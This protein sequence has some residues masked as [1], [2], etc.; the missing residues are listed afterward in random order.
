MTNRKIIFRIV[1]PAALVIAFAC[2]VVWMPVWSPAGLYDAPEYVVLEDGAKAVIGIS[3]DHT[4]Y[5]KLYN[6]DPGRGVWIIDGTWE[7]DPED[8]M[9]RFTFR[10]GR[11]DGVA[12]VKKGECFIW[13]L[14][15]Y[16]AEWDGT[17]RTFHFQR[18]LFGRP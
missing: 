4:C 17:P 11:E 6:E 12:E 9:F 16:D 2:I 3:D 5:V 13:G 10:L 8:G 1:F 7:K 14:K 18:K 15:I